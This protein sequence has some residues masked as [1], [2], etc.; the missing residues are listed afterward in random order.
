LKK[1]RL[2]MVLELYYRNAR[3]REKVEERGERE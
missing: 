2:Y 1:Q 3:E